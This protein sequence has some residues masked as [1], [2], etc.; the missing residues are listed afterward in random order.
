MIL[1][2]LNQRNVKS[3][4]KIYI[5]INRHERYMAGLGL[6]LANP[7]PH[8]RCIARNVFVISRGPEVYLIISQL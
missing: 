5:M 6:E 7:I 3:G 2:S 8:I 1:P 4:L